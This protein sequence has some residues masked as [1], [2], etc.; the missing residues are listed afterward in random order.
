MQYNAMKASARFFLQ[1]K[2]K[3]YMKINQT[4]TN[5]LG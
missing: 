2:T 3:S 5:Y 1:I 4:K